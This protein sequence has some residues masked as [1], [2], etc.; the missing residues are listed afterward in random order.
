MNIILNIL[1]T[2]TLILFTL[3][4]KSLFTMSRVNKT[5]KRIILTDK[6]L[7][8]KF[9]NYKIPY[10]KVVKMIKC[11]YDYKN[12]AVRIFIENN[13]TIDQIKRMIPLAKNISI[14]NDITKYKIH[15][16]EVFNS[17]EI[18]VNIL[19]SNSF[20]LIKISKNVD[21]IEYH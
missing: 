3:D 7:K 14:M 19:N 20:D 18:V 4:D 2:N 10:L 12:I 6:L 5:Y 15:A 11:T 8:Q 17:I 13:L 21:Y 1:D 16:N 9:M